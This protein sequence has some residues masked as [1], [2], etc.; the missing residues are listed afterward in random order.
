MVRECQGVDGLVV[1][2]LAL[3]A[4]EVKFLLFPLRSE[5]WF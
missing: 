5:L 1:E 4:T 3:S 2:Q